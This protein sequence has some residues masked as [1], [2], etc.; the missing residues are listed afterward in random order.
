MTDDGFELTRRKALAGL[1]GI[2]VASTG[3][4]FGTTAYFSDTEKFE[5][6]TLTS[7]ELDL[8]MNYRITYEGGPGRLEELQEHY[9]PEN[10]YNL[11][12]KE[13][14]DGTYVLDQVPHREDYPGGD[15]WVKG[16][17]AVIGENGEL[18]PFERDELV[19]PEIPLF[20]LV[21]VK[22]GD[23]GEAT[24]SLH[25]FDNPGYIWFGGELTKNAQ[26]GLNAPEKRAL[27]A[28]GY[29]KTESDDPEKFAE[30]AEDGELYYNVDGDWGGQ[31]ADAI[32]ARVWYDDNCN[33]V[34]DEG[35]EGEP[36]DISLVVD[37]SGSMTYELGNPGNEIGQGEGSRIFEAREAAKTLAG[38]LREDVGGTGENDRLGVVTFGGIDE[39]L[40][41]LTEA[42]DSDDIVDDL[43]DLE[44]Y[45]VGQDDGSSAPFADDDTPFGIS[46]TN[47]GAGVFGGRGQLEAQG[48]P[49]RRQVMIVLGDGAPTWTYEAEQVDDSDDADAGA[50]GESGFPSY[51]TWQD[52][53]RNDKLIAMFDPGPGNRDVARDD[54][55]AA[56]DDTKDETD[57]EIVSIAFALDDFDGTEFDDPEAARETLADIAS[58]DN[59]TKLYFE[60]PTEL[61]LGDIFGQIGRI[62]FGEIVIAEGTLREV[63]KTLSEGVP[64][65][66]TQFTDERT[67]FPPVVTRCIGFEW[68]LPT[69]VGNEVQSDVV[70]FDLG[71]YAEQCRHND[72]EYNPF[73]EAD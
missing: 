4:G 17:N 9:G 14:E 41:E 44:A 28:S 10:G 16:A 22:P 20:R 47:I 21:D 6:N 53:T 15:G 25:L 57:V 61:E 58:E 19:D 32:Q 69:S 66:A 3:A 64:L 43:D 34:Y 52:W 35:S 18:N 40:I 60:S 65:D 13:L 29:E 8:K 62:L 49:D 31:L 56:A 63:M 33:N 68:E 46:G 26:N 24:I 48:D 37:V 39:E 51:A 45:T 23:Y 30:W 73:A 7:G 72:G 54:T 2:G 71:F 5:E 59:D 36:V 38:N 67:C 42:T 11:E 27:K 70:E 1:G 50:S 55:I 12:P